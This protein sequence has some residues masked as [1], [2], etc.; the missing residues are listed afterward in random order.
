MK[1]PTCLILTGI[2]VLLLVVAIVFI[3]PWFINMFQEIQHIFAQGDEYRDTLSQYANEP[4]TE[5]QEKLLTQL[6]EVAGESSDLQSPGGLESILSAE[7]Y[8]AYIKTQDGQ[9]YADFPAYVTA[10]PTQS[11][12]TVVLSR[13]K[14]FS[15]A[16]ME[17]PEQEILIDFYYIIRDWSKTGKDAQH[18]KKEFDELLQK[19]FVNPLMEQSSGGSTTKVVKTAIVSALMIEDTEV[20]HNAWQTRLK[21]YGTQE[22]YLR[23]AIATPD[24]FA[25]MRSFFE[26]AAAFEKWIA[27]PFK[28]EETTEEQEENVE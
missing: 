3:A 10:M 12:R 8:L 5:E 14:E 19:Y 21:K 4:L 16:E 1:K 13:Y 24:E 7:P 27:E 22:G 18:N 11:H 2:G 28:V 15:E 9:E 26:D 6:L 25:L 20:F 17:V 23:C